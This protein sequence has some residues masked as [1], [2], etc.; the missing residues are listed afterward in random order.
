M[1]QCQWYCPSRKGKRKKQPITMLSSVLHHE[2]NILP[3]L[4]STLTFK[5]SR[6]CKQW[7]RKKNLKKLE[8]FWFVWLPFNPANDSAVWFSKVQNALTTPSLKS[9]F[10]KLLFISHIQFFLAKFCFWWSPQDAL[11]LPPSLLLSK[12]CA[13]SFSCV[14]QQDLVIRHKDQRNITADVIPKCFYRGAIKSLN[15]PQTKSYWHLIKL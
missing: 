8:S 4:L 5:Y 15:A 12:Y 10:L 11:I 1:I 7:N 9:T 2:R 3:C 13:A 14:H 6:N